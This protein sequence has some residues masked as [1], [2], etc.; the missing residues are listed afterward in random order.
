MSRNSREFK[1]LMAR[2]E[3]TT[4]QSSFH[5]SALVTV[6]EGLL[7]Y[8]PIAQMLWRRPIEQST[9]DVI[10]C[11]ETEATS[12]EK[13]PEGN[14]TN[15]GDT[16]KDDTSEVDM[17]TNCSSRKMDSESN[18]THKRTHSSKWLST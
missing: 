6:Y 8:F 5:H 9:R 2:L 11:T 16:L 15:T 4:S 17:S 18:P 3:K 13:K 7:D 1:K 14:T 10:D 12:K